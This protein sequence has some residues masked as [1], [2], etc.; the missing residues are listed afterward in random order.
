MFLYLPWLGE[1]RELSSTALRAPLLLIHYNGMSH[2]KEI[3][4]FVFS[5][6]KSVIRRYRVD[7][8]DWYVLFITKLSFHVLY[9]L[10]C[11]VKCWHFPLL[12]L[13]VFK[14]MRCFIQVCISKGNSTT[15]TQV[16]KQIVTFFFYLCLTVHH[17]CG[18]II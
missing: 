9:F 4:C 6:G 16:S 18:W 2:I 8:Q 11:D 12:Y 13:M 3:F 17:Q 7:Q 10:L 5:S 15:P 14:F 1:W